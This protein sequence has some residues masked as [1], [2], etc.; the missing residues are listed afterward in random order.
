MTDK[1]YEEKRNALIP[2]AE[3][4]ANEKHGKFYSGNINTWRRDW[5]IT[6][7][8]KMDE[9]AYREGIGRRPVDK[10]WRILFRRFR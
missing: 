10:R 1:E 4:Y 6:F 8:N 7:F 9:L 5:T 3:R 2:E